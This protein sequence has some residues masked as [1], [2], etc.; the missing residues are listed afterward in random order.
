MY[1]LSAGRF[2]ETHKNQSAYVVTVV[3]W[4]KEGVKKSKFIA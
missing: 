1:Y 3:F 4:F 2:F